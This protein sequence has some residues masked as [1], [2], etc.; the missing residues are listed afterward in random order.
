MKRG[1]YSSKRI[2][3]LAVTLP[4]VLVLAPVMA[5]VAFLVRLK[6][7]S[8]VIFWQ[9]RPG[10][11]G[12]PFMLLKFRS[13][14]DARDADGGLLPDAQR[15]T[16]FGRML[17]RTSLDE[18]P[19]LLNVL[20]G[21]MSLV[22]PRPLLMRYLPRYSPEQMRR[23]DTPPGITGLAQVSGRNNLSWEDKFALD[24]R[25]VDQCSVWLDIR[26]LLMTVRAVAVAEGVSAPAHISSP[27]FM[28][29]AAGG[30]GGKEGA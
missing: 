9:Q 24:V 22:G 5:V 4:A 3:D 13:M 25:Y 14:T 15:M 29:T 2:F 17:R 19:E 20:K 12:R 6:L 10:C 26:I 16:P 27:E 18:L 30:C 1:P 7:G 23:H 8:P 21:E 11:G 28:G